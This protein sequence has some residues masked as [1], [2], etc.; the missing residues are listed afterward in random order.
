M[1]KPSALIMS[2]S[3]SVASRPNESEL[4]LNLAEL[5]NWQIFATHLPDLTR[6]D[7]EQIEQDNRD[8]RRQ[9]LELYGIWLRRCPNASWNDI[10]IALEKSKENTLADVIKTKYISNSTE[11]HNPVQLSSNQEV[12]LLSEEVIVKELKKLHRSFTSVARDIRC[13]LD[14]LVKSGKSSLHDIVA[15]IE[16]AQVHGMKRLT[17]LNTIDDLFDAIRPH[18]DYLDCELLEMIVEEYLE[19]DDISK[20]KAHIDKVKLFKR[21]TPIKTLKDKL[22]QYTSIPNISEMHLI[23]TIKLQADWG[24]VTLESIEKLVQNLLDYRQ[25]VKI[26]K[27]ESGSISVMLLLPK[28]KLQ[29]FIVSSSQKLQFMRLTGIFRLQIGAITVFEEIENKIFTFESAFLESSQCGDDEAVLFLL[30]LGVNVNY[31]N[32]EGQTA[33]IL[34]SKSGEEEVVKMLISAG[35]NINHHDINGHTALMFSNTINIFLLLLRPNAHIN[36]SIHESST[37]LMIASYLGY[38][39]VVENLLR[40]NNNPNVQN[41]SGWSAII[42]ASRNGHLQVVEL[43]LE[44]NADPDLCT[45]AGCTALM[46]TSHNG[47]HQVAEILL[48]KGANPN[49]QSNS[50]WTALLFASFKGNHQIAE[51]LLE[52]GADPNI[53]SNK[54]GTA[55]MFAIRNGCLQVVEL[56]LK[57]KADPNI[58]CNEGWTPLMVASGNGHLQIGELLLKEK[59]DPNVQDNKGLTALIMA[60]DNGHLQI[61]ELLLKEKADPNV[62][63]NAGWTA[64]MYASDNDNH[65]IAEMLLENGA[66]PNIQSN[67]GVTALMFAIRNGCLQVVELLLKEKADP[68]IH[69]NEGWTPLMVASDNGHLQIVE[70]LLKK[71]ANPNVQ[72]NKGVTALMFASQ[73][74]DL[75]V[76]KLLLQENADPN[77]CSSTRRTALLLA[78]KNGHSKVVALL[79]QYKAN[80]HIEIRKHLDSFTIATVEGNT[81]VVNT[82]LNYFEIRFESLSMGWYYACQFGHVPIIALLSH[83]IDIV[84]DQTDLIISCAE[85]DLGIVV[86]QLMSGKMTPDVQFIHSVTPLMISSSCGHTDIVEALI[87]SGANVNKTDAFGHTA[88]DFTEQAKQ[89]TTRVLLLQHDG[90]R[91]IDLDIRGGTTQI[92]K[93]PLLKPLDNISTEIDNISLQ[94]SDLSTLLRRQNVSTM[95]YHEDTDDTRFRQ[96]PNPLTTDLND[97]YYD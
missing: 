4:D 37:P 80:P 1:P 92:P 44:E 32:S 89:D 46:F 42:F 97:L 2:D 82:F 49:I 33:L 10:V 34:A 8:V 17:E 67:K 59:A 13:K 79:L 96:H 77:V 47:Y 85:G 25:T 65:Q 3:P 94:L 61:G 40:F 91:G 64:L 36:F 83:R 95:K 9:K 62:R 63:N 15:Y 18:N 74:G 45:K 78:S 6:G 28:E 29:H 71:N 41:M 20:V 75:Q 35:A 43:L 24:R 87:Q 52:N 70:L 72:S 55:L 23:V 93:E 68:D 84:S 88:L 11:V 56:L 76:V 26:F 21:T 66:D 14:E 53:Q 12:Y 81:D 7:I 86:D 69:C 31:S 30:G 27:V 90:L 51:M 60:T 16:E 19:D 48:K 73:T 38:I 57:E 58:H 54:G 22:H 50:G 5:V 39:T